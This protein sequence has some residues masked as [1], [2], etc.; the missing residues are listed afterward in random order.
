MVKSLISNPP[1][2]MKWTHPALAEMLPQYCGYELPPESNANYAFVLNGIKK[3][4]G[5]AVFLLPNGVLSTTD[6]HEALIRRQIIEEN[7]LKAVIALPGDMFES[8]SIP[9]CIL[10][11]SHHKSTRRIE[12]VDLRQSCRE[13]TREQKGQYGG[14]SHTNRTYSK[15]VKVIPED[16]TDK[17]IKAISNFEDI[18][19]FCRA[20]QIEEIRVNEYIIVPSR[21]IEIE[22]R[23]YNHRSFEDIAADYNRIVRAKNS[24]KITFNRTAASRL[25]IPIKDYEKKQ[26]ISE[27]FAMVGQTVEKDNYIGFTNN[28]GIKIECSTKNGI[29][30]LI[31]DFVSEWALV[32]RYLND[33]EN[34]ILSEFRDALLPE[35][36]SGKLDAKLAL[37]KENGRMVREGGTKE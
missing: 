7:L 15:T 10:V 8:T 21:Y 16:V 3:T 2:N 29:P 28:D 37:N 24:V 4:T 12:M 33:E 1:Y 25:K 19:E 18:P 11:L 27:P 9:T 31:Q 14:A 30:H 17:T 13:E 36:M 6:K 26:D 35:L 22:K 32:E 34:R 5:S 20:V 23:E